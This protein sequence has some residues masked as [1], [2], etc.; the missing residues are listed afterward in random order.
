MSPLRMQTRYSVIACVIAAGCGSDQS[1]PPQETAD[2]PAITTTVEVKP[3]QGAV[4]L[5]TS[6][7]KLDALGIV[8]FEIP[9][10]FTKGSP[11]K[12]YMCEIDFP[13]TT[14][15]GMR[16]LEAWELKP[17]GVIKT[18]IETGETPVTTFEATFSEAESPDRGY[19]VIS[20]KV[21][22]DVDTTVLKSRE[23]AAATPNGTKEAES[24]P[25]VDSSKTTGGT[26]Q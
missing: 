23:S 4:E 15:K 19:T 12:T 7:A 13:G 17:E 24:E 8:R 26:P 21:S 20:N 9:Y 25:A 11:T 1:A 18:G 5:G 22:G 2:T 10:K 16:P 14:K 6:T 3:E